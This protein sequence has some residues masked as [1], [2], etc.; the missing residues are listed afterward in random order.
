VNDDETYGI[1]LYRR[2]HTVHFIK[3]F[4]TWIVH[5]GEGGLLSEVCRAETW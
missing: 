5:L 3:E 1:W 2:H 4:G